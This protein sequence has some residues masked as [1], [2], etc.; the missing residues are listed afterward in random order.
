MPIYE[1]FILF[2]VIFTMLKFISFVINV[3]TNFYYRRKGRK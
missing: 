2:C 3:A 1:T